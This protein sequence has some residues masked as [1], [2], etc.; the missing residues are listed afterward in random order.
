MSF[1][2]FHAAGHLSLVVLWYY[3]GAGLGGKKGAG[4][5]QS[6]K[7]SAHGSVTPGTTRGS[8]GT[9]TGDTMVTATGGTVGEDEMT[10]GDEVESDKEKKGGSPRVLPL[11]D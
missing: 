9:A 11:K 7:A 6:A 1:F 3:E 5:A 4:V 2:L 10:V 8:A